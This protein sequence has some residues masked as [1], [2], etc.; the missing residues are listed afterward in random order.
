[1]GGTDDNHSALGSSHSQA[2][3]VLP[4]REEPSRDNSTQRYVI[5][6]IT[7]HLIT[8]VLCSKRWARSTH[9]K[10]DLISELT[11]PYQKVII[12]VVQTT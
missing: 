12:L 4:S 9:R 3:D 1:M 10:M 6:F 11:S 5:H 8:L 7:C 2:A